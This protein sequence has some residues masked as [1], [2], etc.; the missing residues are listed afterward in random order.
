MLKIYFASDEN[1]FEKYD[2]LRNVS[3]K[4]CLS[5]IDSNPFERLTVQFGILKSIYIYTY[6]CT[7]IMNDI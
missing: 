4:C 6:F 3:Y 2:N 1:L 5:L 7:V